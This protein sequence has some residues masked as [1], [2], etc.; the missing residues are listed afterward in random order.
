ML[1]SALV[2]VL[3]MELCTTVCTQT[4]QHICAILVLLVIVLRTN[5]VLNGVL[6]VAGNMQPC[7]KSCVTLELNIAHCTI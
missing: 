3:I 2:Q 5:A 1:C 4:K 7:L 6:Q